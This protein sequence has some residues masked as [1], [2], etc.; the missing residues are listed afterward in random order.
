[1]TPSSWFRNCPAVGMS[2]SL[3]SRKRKLDAMSSISRLSSA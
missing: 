3:F 1:M 2:I